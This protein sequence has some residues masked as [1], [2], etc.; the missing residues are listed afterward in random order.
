MKEILYPT[1]PLNIYAEKLQP[2]AS[3]R[4]QA[5][6][7]IGAI[8]LFLITYFVLLAASVVLAAVCCLAGYWLITEVPRLITII[9]GLG[10]I[11][12]GASVIFFMI[13]FIFA[14]S[15]DENDA[16]VEITEEEQPR[17]F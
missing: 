14:V 8:F 15:K 1:A 13:K 2:S 9:I 16:R 11:V 5:I 4:K 6:K 3:F 7:V 17:L 10:L 12:L